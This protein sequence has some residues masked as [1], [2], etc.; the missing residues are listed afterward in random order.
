MGGIAS[1]FGGGG[2]GAPA[3]PPP[4]PKPTPAPKP[5]A[6]VPRRRKRVPRETLVTGPRGLTGEAPVGRKTL[7]GE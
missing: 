4:P 5:A 7:L 2:G 1:L 6:P 3:P